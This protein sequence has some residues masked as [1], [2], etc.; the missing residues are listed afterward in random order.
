MRLPVC[1]G[2]GALFTSLLLTPDAGAGEPIHPSFSSIALE[3]G[4]DDGETYALNT[5]GVV[6]KA[7]SPESSWWRPVRGKYR[8]AMSYEDFFLHLGRPDLAEASDRRFLI[9]STLF[10][11]GF[12]VA[13]GGGIL[14]FH[15]MVESGFGVEAGIGLGLI[16]GGFGAN[17]SSRL[18]NYAVVSPDEAEDMADRYNQALAGY[19]GLSPAG[20]VT[21][22]VALA[23]S[24]RASTRLSIQP[25]AGGGFGGIVVGGSF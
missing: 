12:A 10:W 13:F 5:L 25:V 14:L 3:R 7:S 21:G 19:L 16:V 20:P 24:A 4:S 6:R 11:G 23:P 9:R 15:G 22:P 17:L 1:L 18:V 8:W 2:L